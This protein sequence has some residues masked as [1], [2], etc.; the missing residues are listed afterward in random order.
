MA[1]MGDPAVT[2]PILVAAEPQFFVTD[3]RA[4]VYFFTAKLG[5]DL[6]FLH[7]EPPFYGQVARDG[8][9]LNLRHVDRPLIDRELAAREDYLSAS[10]T[11]AT[12]AEIKRLFLDF[13]SAGVDF[14]QRLKRQP[15]GARNFIVKDPDGNLLLFTGPVE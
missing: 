10:I 14:H 7:G 4:S 13:Q 3:M 6:A 1:G 12:P 5:F 8:A 2:R 9:R 15:W 11:V